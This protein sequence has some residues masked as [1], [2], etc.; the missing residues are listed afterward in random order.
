[1]PTEGSRGFYSAFQKP[2]QDLIYI[3]EQEYPA[4]SAGMKARVEGMNG[5]A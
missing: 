5:H 2:I 3:D 1:M 4:F